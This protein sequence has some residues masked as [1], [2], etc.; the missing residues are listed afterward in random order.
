[1]LA[2]PATRVEDLVRPGHVVPVRIG[3]GGCLER[4]FGPEAAHDLVR[5]AG[6]E[7]GAAFCHVLDG[8]DDLAPSLCEE[9]ARQ[10]GAVAL[11][12]SDVL[13]W[14]AIREVHVRRVASTAID[15]AGARLTVLVYEDELDGSGHLALLH[16]STPEPEPGAGSVPMVRVHSQ[17]LTGDVLHSLRCD[18]GAQLAAALSLVTGPAGGAVIYLSQEGRGIGLANK[19]RAYALQDQGADTVDANL[20]LGFVADQRDYAVA[21]QILADLGLTRIRLLTNNPEKVAALERLGI[22]VLERLPLEVA[23]SPASARYLRTKR[24][25]MGHLLALVGCEAPPRVTGRPEE[26]GSDGSAI[27]NPE[28]R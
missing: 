8:L 20:R 17:C 14:R 25:R 21:G 15:A 13:T 18:C 19:V 5:L 9:R 12:V 7:G 26:P 4:P 28:R 3:A 27:A 6:L 24:D 11:R 16:A 2:D 1:V 22:A 10:I 23:A